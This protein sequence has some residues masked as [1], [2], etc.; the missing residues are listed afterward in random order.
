VTD[1]GQYEIKPVHG[2]KVRVGRL[3]VERLAPL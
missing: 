2:S 1:L 3:Y